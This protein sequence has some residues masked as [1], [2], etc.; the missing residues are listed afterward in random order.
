M[1][2]LRKM[3]VYDVDTIL[4]NAL[5]YGVDQYGEILSD[6]QISDLRLTR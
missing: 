1:N 3:N 6:E 4:E 2:E 5:V